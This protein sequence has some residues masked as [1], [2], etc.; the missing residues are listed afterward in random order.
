MGRVWNI[1]EATR[2]LSKK[3]G[4]KKESGNISRSAYVDKRAYIGPN[5]IIRDGVHI[6]GYS[7]VDCFV[8]RDTIISDSVLMEGSRIGKHCKIFSSVIGRHNLIEDNFQALSGEEATKIY[9]KDK[10]VKPASGRWGCFTGD[11]V[12]IMENVSAS[13]GKIIFPNKVIKKNIDRDLLIRAILFDADNTLYKTQ[14]IAKKADMK[15]MRFFSAKCKVSPGRLYAEWKNIVHDLSQS[16]KP[17]ERHRKYSYSILAKKHSFY[18]PA[19]IEAAFNSFLSQLKNDVK[20]MP[21]LKA[22]LPYIKKNKLAIISEDSRDMLA[23]KL[24]A[25]GLAKYFDEILT[26]DDIGAMKPHPAYYKKIFSKFKVSPAECLVVGDDYHKDL[27]IPKK[28]GATVVC[29]GSSKK[30]D[31]CIKNYSELRRIL[32][33]I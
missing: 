7:S 1:L 12:V 22:I 30:A 24:N 32:D 6:I 20:L 16:K 4:A 2:L 15:A 13:P 23:A 27:S 25:L 8:D 28:L 26:S 5:A 17:E 29:F 10:P 33:D 19:N 14:E 11:N 31:Y 21:G 3:L 18:S 9:V